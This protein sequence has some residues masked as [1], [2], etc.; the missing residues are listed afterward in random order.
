MSEAEEKWEREKLKRSTAVRFCY[1]NN[2]MRKSW[3]NFKPVCLPLLNTITQHQND[4]YYP[5]TV[6]TMSSLSSS[7]SLFCSFFESRLCIIYFNELCGDLSQTISMGMRSVALTYVQIIL[8]SKSTLNRI[9]SHCFIILFLFC[10]LHFRQQ[11][12]LKFFVTCFF[13]RAVF[14]QCDNSFISF[15]CLKRSKYTI[16]R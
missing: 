13:F 14:T 10:L 2:L 4:I 5:F 7:F 3:R 6:T 9:A 11:Q 16:L 12:I 15:A 1:E 8:N